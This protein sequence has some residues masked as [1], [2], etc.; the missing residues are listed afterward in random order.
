MDSCEQ[1]VLREARECLRQWAGRLPASSPWR[2]AFIVIARDVASSLDAE[3][4]ARE[5]RYALWRATSSHERDRLTLELIGDNPPL[6]VAEINAKLEE[7][8]F[9]VA[10]QGYPMV[11]VRSNVQRLHRA[12]ELERLRVPPGT[13]GERAGVRWRFARKSALSG[14]IAELERA[15]REPPAPEA[16]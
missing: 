6:T 12:G 14:P 4:C 15:F 7:E 8:M 11:D 9:G 16:V 5:E 10:P 2:N 13:A 3:Q 1:Q